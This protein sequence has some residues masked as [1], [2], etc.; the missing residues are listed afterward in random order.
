MD[1]RMGVIMIMLVTVFLGFGII[2]PVL[3]EMIVGSGAERFH[4][5]VMLAVYSAA[6][7]VLSP[8]WGSLSDRIGRKP[9]LAIGVL[10]FSVSFLVFGLSGGNLALMYISRVLGGVFSGA[11]TSCAVAYVAD[12]TTPEKRTRAMGLVGM[13]IGLGFIFGPGI[14]GLLS[15][16]G[17]ATPFFAAA[18]LA[19]LNFG[20]AIFVL[21]ESLP[22][23]RRRGA[24]AGPRPSRWS[25]FQGPIAYLF[26]LLF[27]LTFA[28]AGLEST[29]QYFQMERFEA[30]PRDMGVMFLVSGIVGALV[31]GGF[32]RRYAKPGTE[33][34]LIRVGLTVQALGFVLLLF[35]SD[36]WTASLFMSVF[37]VG[38]S[39]L[40]PC[41]T[42]LITQTTQ[43]GQGVTGGLSSS[44]DSLGRI[45]GPLVAGGLFEL[46]SALPFFAGAAISLGAML[47]LQR[48][49]ARRGTIAA[50]PAA[51]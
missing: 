41:V 7:F 22:P 14:G 43:A 37:A 49:L 33:P 46:K 48:F 32:I 15:G 28:L 26:V 31:Q 36:V 4:L 1:R 38:N 44:M 30:T 29:L 23:E 47:L 5:Y 40:R 19:L 18:A 10:G 9:V 35:S 39:L 34:T 21:K 45:A 50:A 20:F 11:T 27:V 16:F 51:K 13:S 12:I 2:I 25:A 24:D 8:L 3:P 17:L 6:S 42:S